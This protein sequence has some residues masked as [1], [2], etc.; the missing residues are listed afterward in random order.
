MPCRD[1]VATDELFG[2]FEPTSAPQERLP[3]ETWSE[4]MSSAPRMAFLQADTASLQSDSF[5]ELKCSLTT[6]I[7]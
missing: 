2:L 5:D 1:D 6:E 3:C 7:R 4:A